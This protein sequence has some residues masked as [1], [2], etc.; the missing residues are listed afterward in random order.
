MGEQFSI[1]KQFG[2]FKLVDENL[3]QWFSEPQ[4]N[5]EYDTIDNNHN[6]CSDC[7]IPME[8]S[9]TEYQC[10]LCGLTSRNETEGTIKDH[11]ETVSANIRITTGANRG[12]F[13]NITSDYTKTQKKMIIDQLLQHQV[14]YA[15]P[16]FPINVLNATATQYNRIQKIITEDEIDENGIV[17]RQKKFVRRGGIKDEVLAGLIY[18]ECIREKLVRKKKDIAT[19]MGL[20][21]NGF[22]RGE[23][24]LRNLEAEGK[25][26][27]PVDEEPIEGFID[28]YLEAL[29]LDDP[30][31]SKFIIDII[32]ESEK[33][34]IG[35]NSQISSKIVGAVWILINRCRLGISAQALEKAADNTKKN[36]FTKFYNIVFANMDVFGMIFDKYNI[37]K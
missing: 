25:I 29:N 13:Y 30:N 12:R 32:V 2:Q 11:D 34:K 36:T 16:S 37:P 17:T 7:N 10:N 35:M 31:Y 26:E 22:A 5:A 4:F 23:N 21:T 1:E 6:Y 33:K 9:G 14:H 19:F 18:F 27:I 15:G 28:R 8:L 24:I 20:V 3:F